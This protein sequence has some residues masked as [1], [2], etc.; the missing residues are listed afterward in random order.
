M[1]TERLILEVRTT[2]TR[3]VERNISRIRKEASAANR[4]LALLRSGLV[5]VAGARVIGRFIELADVLTNVRNRLRLVTT[6]TAQL[7]AVQ[8]GLFRVAQDTRVSFEASVELF[9]RLT[10][11]AQGLELTYQ[12]LLDITKG[13][14]Q[15]ISISGATA[16]EARNSLIQFSQGLASGTLRGDELR[17]VVEQFPRLA[18]AIGK[19]FNVA[20]GEL[21]AFAKENDGILTTERIIKAIRNE[22][23]VL[24]KEFENVQITTSGAF[25]RFNNALV[26]FIGGIS[27]SVRLGEKLDVVLQG[28]A[29]NLPEIAVALI[30]IA[31]IGTFNILTD[32]ALRFGQTLLALSGFIAGPFLTL[33]RAIIFGPIAALR[34]LIALTVA[35]RAATV[36]ATATMAA[37]WTALRASVLLNVAAASIYFTVVTAGTRVAVILAGLAGLWRLVAA[38]TLAARAAVAAFIATSALLSGVVTIVRVLTV[39]LARLLV[40]FFANPVVLA[41]TAVIA[42]IIGAFLLLRKVVNDFI[43]EGIEL[44]QVF[45][46]FAATVLT[47]IDVVTAAWRGLGPA[48]ADSLL[49]SINFLLRKLNDFFNF[50]IEGINAIIE[51][52]NN[53]GA[54]FEQVE[55]STAFQF[56][57]KFAGA[58]EDLADTVVNSF[59]NRLSEG[60]NA[61]ELK[62]KFTD[63]LGFFK[64]FLPPDLDEAA[65]LLLNQTA[66]LGDG[67]SRLSKALREAQKEYAKLREG[68]DPLTAGLKEFGEAQSVVNKLVEAGLLDAA[69]GAE[70][71]NLLAR[72]VTGLSN[73]EF[74]LQQNLKLV[75]QLLE[76]NAIDAD[77]AALAQQK[78]RVE[79]QGTFV[80]ALSGTSPLVE[81]N[82]KLAEV[83][84]FIDENQQRIAASGLNVS[85]VQQ[86]L[87]REAFGLGQTYAQVNEEVQALIQNQE[88]LGIS[89]ADLES[90]VRRLNI[91]YLETQRD[92]ISGAERAFLKLTED[93]TDAATFTE[94]VL[95]D[96]FR[97]IED[98]VVSFAQTGKF[99]VDDFFK[100]L[101]EQLIRFGTQQA[102]ASIGSAFG[103]PAGSGAGTVG[104]PQTG[105]GST[106]SSIGALVGSLAVSAIGSG[107]GFQRGGSFTV[108]A[109]TAAKAIPGIDNRLIAFK[110]RDGETV[111]VTPRGQSSSSGPGQNIVFNIRADDPDAFRKSQTQ[112]ANRAASTVGRAR[113]RR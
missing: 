7:N 90:E 56:E 8:T 1:A 68:L 108:G 24:A 44:G 73:A 79:A 58:G 60:G 32:Q 61:E 45:E 105:G 66:D 89:T 83:Q 17:S 62:N 93:A 20:G 96:A 30:T 3:T 57:N 10:R 59:S 63:L 15:A 23:P 87:A 16:Q 100:N 103:G 101:S 28:I 53:L 55:L 64:D 110:A 9:N 13:V 99:E 54:S 69:E 71:L 113:Q 37:A 39:S 29:R 38:Q 33:G 2:G 77:E 21:A 98:A 11:S 92:A 22:L 91:A 85:E 40:V 14:N 88:T 81:A 49:S 95:T 102:I 112:L 25:Q 65:K 67:T 41:F 111:D 107:G 36:T 74:E 86:R 19:E 51:A 75:N 82:Q 5:V 43:P 72:S 80:S 48:L 50:F 18:N 46:I 12:E 26:L 84:V 47:A 106:A 6:S 52:A 35:V 78:L 4:T 27:E 104:G 70:T 42:A 109:N 97:S 76:Q 34:T 94:M 31:G